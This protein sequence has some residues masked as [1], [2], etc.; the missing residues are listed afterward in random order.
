MEYYL[1]KT[2]IDRGFTD[3]CIVQATSAEHAQDTMTEIVQLFDYQIESVTPMGKAEALAL[4]QTNKAHGIRATKTPRVNLSA[5]T[6]PAPAPNP[7]TPE[8]RQTVGSA[9][10]QLDDD[11]LKLFFK[12][13][14]FLSVLNQQPQLS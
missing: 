4:L 2:E 10:A 7:L 6:N 13:V 9:M 5:L 12:Y 11:A 14:T 3:S 1:V 8:Q